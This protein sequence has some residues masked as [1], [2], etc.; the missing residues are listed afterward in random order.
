MLNIP[1]SCV[2]KCSPETQYNRQ[3]LNTIEFLIERKICQTENDHVAQLNKNKRCESDFL[4][5]KDVSGNE[6]HDMF[7]IN[8]SVNTKLS[9]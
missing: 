8:Y 1:Y 9:L 3:W 7:H 6:A 4:Q 5:Q 2:W